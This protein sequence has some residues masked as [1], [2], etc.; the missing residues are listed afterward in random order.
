MFPQEEIEEIDVARE[1]EELKAI[2]EEIKEIKKKIE[3]YLGEL[4]YGKL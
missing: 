2:E 4:E 3:A 1:W